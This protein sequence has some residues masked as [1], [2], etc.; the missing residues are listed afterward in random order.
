MT[1]STV[2]NLD[3]SA[4]LGILAQQPDD[5]L[6]TLMTTVAQSAI[7]AQFQEFIGVE[8]YERNEDAR[9]FYRNGSRNRSVDTRM[10]TIDLR[11]PRARDGNFVPPLVEHR[12]RSERALVAAVQEMCISGVS[13][14]KIE[15]VLDALGVAQM[16][17]SQVS[18]LCAE[19]DIMV[20]AFRERKLTLAYPY[21]M[22]DALYVSMRED[23]RV[24]KQAVVIAYGINEHGVREV[25]GVDVVQ[26][27]SRESWLGF[28]RSLIAREL[29]GVLL[30]VSDAHE[31]LKAAIRAVFGATARWQRCRVHFLRNILAHVSKHRKLELAEAFR[32]ILSQSTAEEAR[33]RAVTVIEQYGKSCPKAMEILAAGLED[34]LSFYAFPS[35]HRRKLWS[36]NPI[37]HLNGTLRKRT[38]V[39]G[40]FPNRESAIRLVSMLLI[41]QTEDWINE[42]SYMSE[43]SMQLAMSNASDYTQG[44]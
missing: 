8:H 23:G 3:R 44:A 21:L 27:E 6:Q 7:D 28:L 40:V 18:V 36:S 25:I 33:T 39:V 15:N 35:V 19:L 31:G 1:N 30:V 42:R 12:K 11:I 32:S 29:R 34:A 22:F 38:N 13:T 9:K 24:A 37:E 17:K 14:R 5:V 20:K 2:P 16:S 41:E 43:E 4:L 26:T 10:G